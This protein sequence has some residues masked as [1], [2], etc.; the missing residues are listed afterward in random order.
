MLGNNLKTKKKKHRN[1]TVPSNKHIKL[2]GVILIQAA[3]R[4]SELKESNIESLCISNLMV[5]VGHFQS[6]PSPHSRTQPPTLQLRAVPQHSL[7]SMQLS[8][9]PLWEAVGPTHGSCPQL[10]LLQAKQS[11]QIL[12]WGQNNNTLP[13]MADLLWPY[14]RKRTTAA[15]W[16]YKA[17]SRPKPKCGPNSHTRK[18]A[19]SH[20]IRIHKILLIHLQ[21]LPLFLNILAD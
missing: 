16:C 5:L 18:T 13:A 17:G 19:P 10:P 15:V 21:K 8:A 6:S 20:H 4:F 1:I 3:F 14:G 7:S 11:K 12:Y 9:A 2:L